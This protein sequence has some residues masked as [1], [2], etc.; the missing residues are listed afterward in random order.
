MM[1]TGME[2]PMSR[3][4][5]GML[6]IVGLAALSAH[7]AKGQNYAYE[8]LAQSDMPVPGYGLASRFESFDDV[9]LA[10]DGSIAFESSFL[11]S[12]DAA[13]VHEN[14]LFVVPA[15]ESIPEL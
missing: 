4:T 8:A 6:A 2:T 1:T 12:L 11:Q 5:I 9:L 10:S 15:G 14:G 3:C 13:A 7:A